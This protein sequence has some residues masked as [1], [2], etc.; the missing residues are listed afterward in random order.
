LPWLYHKLCHEPGA[1]G[2]TTDAI[3]TDAVGPL[4]TTL[5]AEGLVDLGFFLRYFDEDGFHL[6][7]RLHTLEPRLA[8]SAVD[9]RLRGLLR[10]NGLDVRVAPVPYDPETAK[11][12]G[13]RGIEVAEEQFSASSD[14][15]LECITATRG[16]LCARLLLAADAMRRT[17]G[18]LIADPAARM[19]VVH[20]YAQY[21]TDY[22][23]ALTNGN[24][25]APVVAPA[26]V[27][28]WRA[29]GVGDL[30]DG[31]G[32]GMASDIW[33]AR[34]AAAIARLRALDRAAALDV[35]PAHIGLNLAH[36]FHNRLGLSIDDELIVAGLLVHG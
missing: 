11:Y 8:E 4:L 1:D 26:L 18:E 35:A 27:E 5:R 33:Q 30:V 32:I 15:A 7:L 14:F 29:T 28:L 24:Y 3:L 25:R 31:L 20:G 36:T 22:M 12:G 2:E 13:E 34:T 6:R 10:S 9:T 16:R 23:G 21:W 17:V 19:A